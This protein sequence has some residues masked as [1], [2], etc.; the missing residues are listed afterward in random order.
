LSQLVAFLADISSKGPVKVICYFATCACVD[1]FARILGRLAEL[2]HL[3]V[4]E[5]KMG[6]KAK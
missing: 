4:G 3:P 5:R 6:K 1:Y 2:K